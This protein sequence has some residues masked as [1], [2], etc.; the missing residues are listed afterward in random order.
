V[1]VWIKIAC[2]MA[3]STSSWALAGEG[4]SCHFHGNK[5]APE[6]TVL[7]C[8]EKQK[9]RLIDKGTIA[10][11]WKTIKHTAIEQV[12]GKKGKEWK[13]TYADPYGADKDKSNLYMFFTVPGNFIAANFTGK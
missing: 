11:T 4:S 13:I 6:A 10:A 7:E 9:I 1:T 8:A 2:L 3:L 12:D 5:P